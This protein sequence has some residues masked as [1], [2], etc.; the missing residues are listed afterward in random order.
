MQCVHRRNHR[1][2]KKGLFLKIAANTPKIGLGIN[3]NN[4]LAL[5][6][7]VHSTLLNFKL[8]PAQHYFWKKSCLRVKFYTKTML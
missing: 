8:N 6:K 7:K 4:V 3:L 1:N 2:A 5:K